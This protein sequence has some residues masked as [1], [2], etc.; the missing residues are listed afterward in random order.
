MG[1]FE[2]YAELV[3]AKAMLAD[4]QVN[5]TQSKIKFEEFMESLKVEAVK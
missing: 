1:I 3:K 4:A 2:D 5:A